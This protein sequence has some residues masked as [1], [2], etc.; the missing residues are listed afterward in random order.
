MTSN[1]PASAYF[2]VD[3]VARPRKATLSVTVDNEVGALA[4]VVGLFSGRGYNIESLTVAETDHQKHTSRITIVTS[5]TNEVITQIMAQIGRL[6]P[7]HN[8]VDLAVE[9][10]G[11]E[12]EMA[13]I[14]VAGEGDRRAETLRLSEVFR[15]RVIDITHTSFVFELT[16]TPEK[17]DA[18][19]E[20]MI[21]LGMVEYSRTGVVAIARGSEAQ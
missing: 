11:V 15:A 3:D 20:L 21:P 10:P 14:K 9:K 4:R 6:I 5:G 1:Q 18:F 8:V 12:R 2:L 7:V 13:L 19:V 16:G 17:I